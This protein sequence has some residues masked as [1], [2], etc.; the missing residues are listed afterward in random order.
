LLAEATLYLQLPYF[1]NK[2]GG[3]TSMT[4]VVRLGCK[5]DLE[6]CEQHMRRVLDEDLRGYHQRWHH[7][8]ADLA[9]TYLD[10]PGCALF[11]AELDGA[12]AGTTTVK[13]G[14][15]ASPPSPAWLRSRYAAQQTGQLTRV[16]IVRERRR[17]GAA[18]ALVTA[19]AQWA[20]GPGG[21]TVVCLH[22]DASSPGALEF[23]RAYPGA[24]E[25]YDARP[26]PWDTVYFELDAARL[27]ELDTARPAGRRQARRCS[28]GFDERLAG[29]IGAVAALSVHR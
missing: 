17:R 15:P 20:L 29:G 28:G 13:P 2:R 25:I 27:P 26:D 23:W 7:D 10:R 1:G 21:Y 14:G 22:T 9:G 11:V 12:F 5:E 24:V 19:A 16:W 8:V 3:R 6:V 4:L 18:R